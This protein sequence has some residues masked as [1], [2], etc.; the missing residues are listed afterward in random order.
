[1]SEYLYVKKSRDKRKEQMVY[2][3]GGKCQICGYNKCIAAL[4]FHHINPQEKSFAFN[5]A[6]NYSWDK[7]IQE[8]KKCV[9]VCA[10]CHREIEY[11]ELNQ[12]LFSSFDSSKAEEVSRE[13]EQLK[14][15][16]IFYCKYCGE[17]VSKGNDCCVKCSSKLRQKIER[18]NREKL[19]ELIRNMTFVQIG[20]Q[21]NVSDNAIR[22]WCITYN[23]PSKKTEIKTYTDEEWS[24][25]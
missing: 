14:T 21:Y 7:I 10:N 25:I 18:P 15:H 8:L 19:K 13:I 11:G 17:I 9:L 24:K 5:K 22:K 3:M 16:Q 23:L 2:V 20:Q 6:K 4:D 12:V 1:M